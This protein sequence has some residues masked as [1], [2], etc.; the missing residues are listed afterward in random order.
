MATIPVSTTRTGTGASFAAS[1]AASYVPEISADRCRETM[2]EAPA[3]A[4]AR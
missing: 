1:S 2:P 3:S 4:A